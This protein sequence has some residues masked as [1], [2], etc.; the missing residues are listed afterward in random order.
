MEQDNPGLRSI[1]IVELSVVVSIDVGV[2]QHVFTL[3]I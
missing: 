2:N 3:F 1:D